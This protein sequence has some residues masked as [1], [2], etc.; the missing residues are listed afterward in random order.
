MATTNTSDYG[1]Q[2]KQAKSLSPLSDVRYGEELNLPM[3]I[4]TTASDLARLAS[5]TAPRSAEGVAGMSS[6]HTPS[7][8][9]RQEEQAE[10]NA[11]I[12]EVFDDIYARVHPFIEQVPDEMVVPNFLWA[13]QDCIGALKAQGLLSRNGDIDCVRNWL[14]TVAHEMVQLAEQ[15][16][17]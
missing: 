4:I 15:G 5:T 16:N 12:T 1:Q 13:L 14:I 17:D 3:T 10:R 7:A 2:A 8:L 6:T 9:R 11:R